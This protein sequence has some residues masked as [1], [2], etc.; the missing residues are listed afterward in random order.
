MFYICTYT[1][2]AQRNQITDGGTCSKTPLLTEGSIPWLGGLRNN[3]C[4]HQHFSPWCGQRE[5]LKPLPSRGRS[6]LQASGF[7]LGCGIPLGVWHSRERDRFTVRPATH[8][9][10]V[11]RP[12]FPL[13]S[14]RRGRLV[15]LQTES[16]RVRVPWGHRLQCQWPSLQ[17]SAC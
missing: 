4:D 15:V 1:Y 14:G 3:D 13:H 16:H 5:G 2:S 10:T 11:P 8:S 6:A 7:C 17:D 12:P 9:R